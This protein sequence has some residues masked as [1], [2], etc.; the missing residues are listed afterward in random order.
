[1]P[2]LVSPAV[3]LRPLDGRSKPGAPPRRR[4]AQRLL[5]PARS[6]RGAPPPEPAARLRRGPP[7]HPRPA[8]EPAARRRRGP[9]APLRPASSAR[10]SESATAAP[11][12]PSLRPAA[13]RAGP[14]G[15]RPPA[16]T[17]GAPTPRGPRGAAGAP[18]P[19]ALA[20]PPSAGAPPSAPRQ[21]PRRVGARPRARRRASRAR[22]PPPR[23]RPSLGFPP[24]LTCGEKPDLPE[25]P[26]AAAPAIR[27]RR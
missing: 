24:R 12:R 7:A 25:P 19:G 8:P 9:L 5:Q 14:L 16:G 22:A 23:A 13:V 18:A 6:A 3:P 17:G 27:G 26:P 10:R 1:M 2:G 4:S 20:A 21:S 15:A 11:R